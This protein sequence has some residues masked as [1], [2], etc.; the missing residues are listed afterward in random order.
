M[1]EKL[2]GFL[3]SFMLHSLLIAVLFL[4]IYTPSI[5]F[6]KIEIVEFGYNA[7]ANNEN[8]IS[9]EASSPASSGIPDKGSQSNL[10]PEK[11]NLPEAVSDSNEPLYFPDKIETAYNNL[12]LDENTGN[13]SLREQL[14]DEIIAG[15]DVPISEKPVLGSS[16][17]YLN[18]LSEKI[19]VGESG[20]SPYILEGE[21]TTRTIVKKVIPEYPDNFQQN[22]RVKI[23]FEVSSN[24]SVGNMI[25]VEKSDPVLEDISMNAIEQWKF[26]TLTSDITQIGFITFV[27]QLN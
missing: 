3:G 5:D 25:I 22:A 19:S 12:S 6:L 17:N 14:Q 1:N 18:S 21:I 13:R 10:I 15:D 7:I 4:M 2:T 27:F 9:P 11:V 23:R 24:G 16:E 20:D 26:N 8:F